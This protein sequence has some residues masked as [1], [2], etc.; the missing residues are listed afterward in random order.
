M[1]KE[2]V[3]PQDRVSDRASHEMLG[4][5][6]A[7]GV[8][9]CFTRID[10]Q[11]KQCKF[12]VEGVCCKICHM[13]PCKITAK[14]PLGVCGANADTIVARNFL[15]EVTGGTAAHSDHARHLV[16]RLKAIGEGKGGDYKITDEKAL[17]RIAGKQN[18]GHH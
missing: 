9:T 17:I 2:P 13:G 12:G 18:Q 16:L 10:Q 5:A 6:M 8:D 3:N 4:K 1:A 11:G 7:E 14:A 15:R